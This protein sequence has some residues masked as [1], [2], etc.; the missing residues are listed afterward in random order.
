MVDKKHSAEIA[1]EVE[2]LEPVLK[3]VSTTKE[4]VYVKFVKDQRY[5]NMESERQRVAFAAHHH[6]V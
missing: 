4:E 2:F 6:H 1:N 5:A 3:Y